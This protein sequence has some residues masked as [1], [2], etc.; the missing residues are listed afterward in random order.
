[1]HS[2]SCLHPPA[3]QYRG[4]AFTRPLWGLEQQY[5]GGFR[6]RAGGS[7]DQELYT[8]PLCGLGVDPG[9]SSQRIQDAARGFGVASEEV[10]ATIGRRTWWPCRGADR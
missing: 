7:Q 5:L 9:D 3:G 2:D 1:M 10:L 4:P 6:G 8:L